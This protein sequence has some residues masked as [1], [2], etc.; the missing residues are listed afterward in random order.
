MFAWV[1]G[2]YRAVLNLL[3]TEDGQVLLTEDGQ[4]LVLE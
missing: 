4:E 1:A 2:F 3:L